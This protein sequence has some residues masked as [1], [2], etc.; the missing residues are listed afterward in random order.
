MRLA[1]IYSITPHY[2]SNLENLGKFHCAV[3]L[4][5]GSTALNRKML[6]KA[7]MSTQTDF[8]TALSCLDLQFCLDL[9]PFFVGFCGYAQDR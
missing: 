6:K 5:V 8:S 9:Q 3:S 7:L 1:K 2:Q 4:Y